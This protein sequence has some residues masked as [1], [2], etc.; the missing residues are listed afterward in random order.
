MEAVIKSE[1]K[2]VTVFG[3]SAT[4]L[5]VAA[6]ELVAKFKVAPTEKLE[7]TLAAEQICQYNDSLLKA[8]SFNVWVSGKTEERNERVI[9][10]VVNYLPDTVGF[11]EVDPKWLTTLK[12]GLSEL[13]AYVGEGRNGGNNGEYN[14]IFYK[15]DIFNL[16]DSGTK[17]LSDTPDRVSKYD[18][19]SL[20]RIY[21]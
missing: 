14:P 6:N 15:K 17:W 16:I 3:N 7:L 13:Y 1:G 18:E 4:S 11:Q 21:T 8:M 20:N 5:L 19:S 10:M 12:A 2:T 9:S